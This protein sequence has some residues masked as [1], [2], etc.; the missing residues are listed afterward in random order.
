MGTFLKISQIEEEPIEEGEWAQPFEELDPDYVKD[1]NKQHGRELNT[2]F[3]P[4]S[5]IEDPFSSVTH[6]SKA[7][8]GV[9]SY[10][11][12]PNGAIDKTSDHHW[13]H[14][15]TVQQ[16]ILQRLPW[17]ARQRYMKQGEK[18]KS[19]EH[20]IH[21]LF[22]GGIRLYVSEFDA[23]KKSVSITAYQLPTSL[24]MNSLDRFIEAQQPTRVSFD[25]TLVKNGEKE[26]LFLTSS[27]W[28]DIKQAIGANRLSS[29]AP[30]PEVME[31]IQAIRNLRS[32]FY[33]E[34]YKENTPQRPL[35]KGIDGR[36]KQYK[37]PF[38]QSMRWPGATTIH[39]LIKIAEELDSLE[40]HEDADEIDKLIRDM[41]MQRIPA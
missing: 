28:S 32:P 3:D 39:N 34:N 36:P 1:F 14:L 33:T 23:N 17:E 38:P 30:T 27:N 15:T 2:R 9:G 29:Q 6:D 35:F 12:L 40:K 31:R 7:V 22:K 18:I 16:S 5:N 20:G 25:G 4:N 19:A 37:V 26:N 8:S 41:Y 24:Q 10:I 13:N 21:N 11:L